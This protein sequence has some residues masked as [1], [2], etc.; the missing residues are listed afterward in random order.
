MKTGIVNVHYIIDGNISVIPTSMFYEEMDEAEYRNVHFETI[1]NNH[2]IQSQ[3]SSSMEYAVKY[4]QKELPDGISIACCQSCQYGHF[5]PY[6]DMENEIFCLKDKAPQR[7]EDVV[8][9]FSEPDVSFH[10]RSRKLLAICKDY[11]PISNGEI[12]TYNDW[13]KP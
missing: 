10:E 8:E 5:N 12:Y 1:V 4:L 9:I 11:K 13:E 3:S 2:P 7:R 6:G